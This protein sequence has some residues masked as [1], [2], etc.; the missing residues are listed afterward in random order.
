MDASGGSGSNS[1]VWPIVDDNGAM[2]MNG[3]MDN[4]EE[5]ISNLEMV[6]AYLKNKK[7]LERHENKP[8]KVDEDITEFEVASK[9]KSFTSKPKKVTA[10]KL[11]TQKVQTKAFPAK[12]PVLIR[13]CILGLAATHTWACTGNKTFETRKPK[14]AI[15]A[16]QARKGKI[17]LES[18]KSAMDNSFTFGSNEEVDHVKILQSC[19]ENSHDDSILY[20]TG[21]FRMAFDLTKLR[22]YK[23]VQLFACLHVELK[24]QV[25]SSKEGNWSL[26]R[27]WIQDL[28]K[29][30]TMDHSFGSTKEVDHVSSGVFR[31]AFDPRKS[32][33]YKVVQ[34]GGESGWSIWTSVWSI[35]LGEGEEDA[36]V[37]INLSGKLVKYKL[38][39]KTNIEI[40]DIGSNQMDVD[41]VVVFIPSF[42]VDQNLYEFI[43]SL[44]S[45]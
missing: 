30:S 34:A 44:E 22:D 10:H 9:S 4:L 29:K 16:G 11:V 42:E 41:D 43:P 23:M 12:S 20:A 8:N 1:H 40:F 39:S 3:T 25:Y 13:N 45:V 38:I 21:V 33:H 26:C 31:L 37:V 28:T 19:N 15:V 18:R 14:D 6:F 17:R 5:M 2:D 7:M 35:C 27:D 32:I 36:F 24:I